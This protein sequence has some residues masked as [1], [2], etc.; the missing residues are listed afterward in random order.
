[1]ILR[2]GH[3]QDLDL[4]LTRPVNGLVAIGVVTTGLVQC[5]V[6][7][8]GDGASG[9]GS[10][11]ARSGNRVGGG[12]G[13][14]ARRGNWPGDVKGS[15]ARNWVMSADIALSG[16]INL[17]SMSIPRWWHASTTREVISGKSLAVSPTEAKIEYKQVTSRPEHHYLRSS[18]SARVTSSSA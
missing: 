11:A 13:G 17:R 14:T 10:G 12:A 2:L 8:G 6:A 3:A 5:G 15:G 9:G 4:A 7:G 1:M 18:T 16:S